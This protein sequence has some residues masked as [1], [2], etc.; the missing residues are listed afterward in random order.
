MHI[1]FPDAGFGYFAMAS[2]LFVT[3]TFIVHVA[4]A[5][6]VNRDV[7]NL[8]KTGI[9]TALVGPALWTVAILVGGVFVACAY[10]IIHHSNL[11]R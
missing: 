1:S 9:H 8:E 5:N 11:S 10:W 2:L 3:L 6:A 4:F 7:H